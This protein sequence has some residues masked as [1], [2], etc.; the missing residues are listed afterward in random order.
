MSSDII[1]YHRDK[2]FA[3]RLNSEIYFFWQN[4]PSNEE[5]PASEWRPNI[6]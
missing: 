6:E 2:A 1:V 4:I 3:R 5:Q